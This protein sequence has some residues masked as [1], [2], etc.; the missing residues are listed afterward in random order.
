MDTASIIAQLQEKRASS[1]PQEWRL[2]KEKIDPEARPIDVVKK[3]GIL[4][5]E[6]LE[7]TEQNATE[8]LKKIHSG[9]LTSQAVTEA[10]LKRAALAHQ[11]SN[12][13]TEFFPDE[14]RATAK[15]LDGI[16][17][18]SGKPV[19]PLHGLPIAIKVSTMLVNL[20]F[21]LD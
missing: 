14:A 13:L 17:H 19:G 2:S 6:E 8:I 9:E 10:F 12:C 7:L 3:A 11:V 4:T 1:I 18:K 21:C 15:T 5:R 16:F 20:H